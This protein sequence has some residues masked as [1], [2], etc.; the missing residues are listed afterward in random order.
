M[1]A[2]RAPALGQAPAGGGAHGTQAQGKIL[3]AEAQHHTQ[4][5]KCARKMLIG[6]M[7]IRNTSQLCRFR[8]D[9]ATLGKLYVPQFLGSGN[10]IIVCMGKVHGMPNN[11]C[12]DLLKCI[13][14]CPSEESKEQNNMHDMLPVIE[15]RKKGGTVAHSCNPSY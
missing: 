13:T 5:R 11:T 12:G 1:R 9:H 3:K 10:F 15:K 4:Q 14:P 6:Q 7:Q 2:W 8:C